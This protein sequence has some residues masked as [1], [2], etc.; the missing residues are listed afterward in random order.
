MQFKITNDNANTNQLKLSS[1][2]FSDGNAESSLT[3]NSRRKPEH[4]SCS[5]QNN[6]TINAL[7]SGDPLFEE[8]TNVDD[9]DDKLVD[10]VSEYVPPPK[11]QPIMYGSNMMENTDF[12][13]LIDTSTFSQK[14]HKKSRRQQK[15]SKIRSQRAYT[16]IYPSYKESNLKQDKEI[17][18]FY[19]D[20][21]AP[22]EPIKSF[23]ESLMSIPI[24]KENSCDKQSST[25]LNTKVDEEEEEK[26]KKE[27]TELSDTMIDEIANK[28]YEK[29]M[30]RLKTSMKLVL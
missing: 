20:N 4:S 26:V 24:L 3:H 7:L 17:P 8:N 25:S 19:A 15:F 22:K 27:E 6:Q 16:P 9:E 23:T 21:L 14:P 30:E 29:V 2:V 1:S 28:V 11:T 5:V 13:E 12:D 18:I 10:A